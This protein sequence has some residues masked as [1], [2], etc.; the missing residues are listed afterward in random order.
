MDKSNI[1][2]EYAA[3]LLQLPPDTIVDIIIGIIDSSVTECLDSFKESLLTDLSD[4]ISNEEVNNGFDSLKSRFISKMEPINS[5]LERFLLDVIFKIPDHVLL[6][7][8]SVQRVKHSEKQRKKLIKEIEAVK[9]DIQNE[10]F[11]KAVLEGKLKE[12]NNTLERFTAVFS[13]VET[14]TQIFQEN[15]LTNIKENVE[16]IN[17]KMNTYRSQLKEL[18]SSIPS[19]EHDG[20]PNLNDAQVKLASTFQQV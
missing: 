3:Q 13:M 7:E 2:S 11:M 5:K 19:E 12:A 15:N 16:F 17:T 9:I 4:E 10:L 18:K 20:K 1:S 6:P 8:D 14:T